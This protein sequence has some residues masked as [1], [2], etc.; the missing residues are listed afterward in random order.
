MSL[1][2]NEEAQA[3]VATSED[4]SHLENLSA[5][6][7]LVAD[8]KQKIAHMRQ[9][10]LKAVEL[11]AAFKEAQ[12]AY[13]EYKAKVVVAAMVNAGVSKL[14]DEQGNSITLK[15]N[16]YLNP[17]KNDQDRAIIAA[18][19]KKYQG[20][21]LLK[22]HA[23]VDGALIDKLKETGVPFADKTDVNTNSLKSF[24]IDLLGYKGGL[25]R[26]Q[27]TDIPDCMHFVVEQEVVSE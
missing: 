11:E 5:A 16:Y 6:G 7:S 14:Q 25:A 17:N 18:W 19:I 10:E 13:E 9:L 2:P 22:H 27:L 24:L 3:G 12:R 15:S 26:I 4:L 23:E 8:L 20:D 1:L 21:H